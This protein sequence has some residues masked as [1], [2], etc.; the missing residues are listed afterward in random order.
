MTSAKIAEK[1]V[2]KL[3]NICKSFGG[4]VAADHISLEVFPGEVVGLIG[5]NGSGKTTLLNMISGI[6]SADSGN[7]F[8]E[9]RK[10]TRTSTHHRAK[11]GIARTF[12]HPRLLGRCDIFTNLQVGKDLARRKSDA[13]RGGADL[14]LQTLLEAAGLES[15]NLGE[16]IE[17]LSYGQQKLLEIVRA[18]IARPKVMLVDEPAAGLNEKEMEF[19]VRL[20]RLAVDGGIGV[21]II[22]HS[23][24]LIMSIC[25]RITVLNF[26]KQIAT[27]VPEEVQMNQE[28]INAYLGGDQ[29]ADD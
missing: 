8:F 28:V 22:E 27:G 23:M 7:L 2:L 9:G 3:E 20:I 26:G 24:D 17:K 16:S 15:V 4:V 12:Q 18:L 21:V 13:Q 25:D 14:S 11:L 6:Y 5:P 1:P 10:I 19:I 29:D